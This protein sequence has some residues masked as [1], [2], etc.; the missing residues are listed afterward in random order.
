MLVPFFNEPA[1]T[2]TAISQIGRLSAAPVVPFYPQRIDNGRR[3]EINFYPALEDFPGGDAEADAL[4]VHA[5][6]EESIR[7]AP[8]QYYWVHRRF[9]GRPDTLP[10]AYKD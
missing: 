6:L 8:E 5:F 3:Y 1:M 7:K 4:R 2:N 10:N 9:K